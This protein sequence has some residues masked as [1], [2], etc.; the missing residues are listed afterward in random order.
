LFILKTTA[1]YLKRQ[2]QEHSQTILIKIKNYIN[3][4]KQISPKKPAQF[5]VCICSFLIANCVRG[6]TDLYSGHDG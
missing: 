3:L 6:N 5:P 2:Q 4:N 1:K